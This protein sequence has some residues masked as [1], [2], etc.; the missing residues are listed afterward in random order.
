MVETEIL[1][2]VSKKSKGLG[3]STQSEIELR[4]IIT[5]IRGLGLTIVYSQFKKD[6]LGGPHSI[7]RRERRRKKASSNNGCGLPTKKGGKCDGEGEEEA[8]SNQHDYDFLSSIPTKYL[9][10]CHQYMVDY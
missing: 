6:D 8:L 3:R 7:K 4:P 2:E 1:Q 10:I 5:K 9:L